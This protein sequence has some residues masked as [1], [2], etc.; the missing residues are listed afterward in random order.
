MLDFGKYVRMLPRLRQIGC[1]LLVVTLAACAVK[2]TNR[3][4]PAPNGDVTGAAAVCSSLAIEPNGAPGGDAGPKLLGR[5]YS[6]LSDDGKTLLSPRFDWSGNSITA[7]FEATDHITVKLLLEAQPT[8]DPNVQTV[9][10]LLFEFVVDDLPPATRQITVTTDAKGNPTT[11]PLEAYEVTGLD[12]SKP[13][14]V[15]IYRNT[16]AEKGIID[17]NGF[18]LHG[19]HYLPPTRRARR[20]EFIGDSITCG[21]GLEGNNATCP[22]S[23]TIRS[24]VDPTTG[25]SVLDANGN[26]VTVDLPVTE[27]QYL[28]YVAQAARALDA[29]P[30]TY[31]WSGRGV[32]KNLK[33]NW[34]LG[35]TSR[36]PELEPDATKTVPDLWNE[37]TL[38]SDYEGS[39]AGTILDGGTAWDFSVE[40]PEDI[41]QVVVVNLGTNDFSR[42]TK[43]NVTGQSNMTP[44]KDPGDNIPDGDLDST[45][46]LELF[47]QKYLKFVQQIRLHR[48]Q[49]HIFLAT[50]P[51]LSDQYP[52]VNARSHLKAILVRI[53]EEMQKVGDQKV[54][55]MDLVEMGSRYGLG[56][57]YHPNRTVHDIMAT[58]LVG[59]IRSKT[60]W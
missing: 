9:Q 43:N 29:D 39:D 50:P 15:V 38:G 60:C 37:R 42:D 48:P 16:E 20:V 47:F 46:E 3:F 26:P 14:E 49:A 17:F 22:Y 57:D 59:A 52:L 8:A 23:V 33:E 44:G 5:F 55:K 7:R 2:L 41:P 6:P 30:V 56:C 36:V 4:D 10:D 12:A 31:C 27:N 1:S 34:V 11:T 32:Y 51:M 25:K 18:D 13:H 35:A 28:T 24:L 54:Y 21:Y 40:K 19:G 58:Q 53:V 45:A